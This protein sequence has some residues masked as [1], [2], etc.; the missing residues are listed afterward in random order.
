MVDQAKLVSTTVTIVHL[1]VLVIDWLSSFVNVCLVD[2]ES[3]AGRGV[4]IGY[5]YQW[6]K[7]AY[8]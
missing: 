6:W 8:Y 3:S 2:I 5:S 7:F 4:P 1:C